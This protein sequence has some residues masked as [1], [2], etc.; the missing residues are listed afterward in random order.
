MNDSPILSK[1]I[2]ILRKI[3]GKIRLVPQI[4]QM[5]FVSVMFAML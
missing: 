5:I 4:F 3:G 1:N 2:L